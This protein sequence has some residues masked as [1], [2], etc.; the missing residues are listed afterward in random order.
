MQSSA[1]ARPIAAI[2]G[3]VVV[4]KVAQVFFPDV[5]GQIVG[6]LGSREEK[7]P[8]RPLPYVGTTPVEEGF[9]W[10]KVE[11]EKFRTFRAAE[12]KMTMGLK[13]LDHDDWIVIDNTYLWVSNIRAKILAQHPNTVI[14]FHESAREAVLELYDAVTKFLMQ[15][16]PMYFYPVAANDGAMKLYNEIRDEY[17][18][19]HSGH[20]DDP[21]E[22][23]KVLAVTINDDLIVLIKNPAEGDH[24]EYHVRAGVSLFPAGFDPSFKANKPLTT[25]HGPVPG[26]LSKLQLS[27]NKFFARLQAGELKYR[28]NWSIQTHGKLFALTENH[29]GEKKTLEVLDPDDLDF[30]KCFLRCE[31]QAFTHLPNSECNVMSVKTYVYPL[32]DIRAEGLGETLCGAIDGLPEGMALY[33]RA[34]GWG[35]AVKKYMRY[36]SDGAVKEIYKYQFET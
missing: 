11:P 9:D 10:K 16:Y 14:S 30:N 29:A 7:K 4:A 22:A 12:Y 3:V 25:I 31:K 8:Q 19:L 34:L 21:V 20:I 23:L 28:S 33:K 17:L 2:A 27:M 24:D 1:L 15:R 5:Y 35:P 18:P 36:E 26:Y 32:T 13:T 6:W